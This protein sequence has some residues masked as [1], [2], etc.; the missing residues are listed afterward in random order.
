MGNNT[1]YMI[2]KLTGWVDSKLEIIYLIY[3][4]DQS[5]K[6]IVKYTG[7]SKEGKGRYWEKPG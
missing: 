3:A 7:L 4:D 1:G 6:Q 2:G 5:A